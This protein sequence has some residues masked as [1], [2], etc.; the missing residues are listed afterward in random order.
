MELSSDN[1]RIVALQ[2]AHQFTPTLRTTSVPFGQAHSTNMAMEVSVNNSRPCYNFKTSHLMNQK[3]AAANVDSN[4]GS[5]GLWAPFG[6][7]DL[8]TRFCKTS[9]FEE[10]LFSDFKIF[11]R[12][13]HQTNARLF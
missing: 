2:A 10:N 5:K 4:M 1:S 12:N 11:G 9:V 13:Y 8:C 6:S 3:C 7:R